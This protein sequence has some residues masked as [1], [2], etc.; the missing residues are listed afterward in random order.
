[1]SQYYKSS[2]LTI[3]AGKEKCNDGFFNIHNECENHPG[4]GV[5]KDLLSMSFLCPDGR[6]GTVYFKEE[7]PYFLSWEPIS[8]RAWTLQERVLSPRVLSYG[9]RLVWQCH[10]AQHSEGGVED[11]S[12]DTRASDHRKLQLSF[13]EVHETIRDG[14]EDTKSSSPVVQLSE[15]L[16]DIRYRA[17]HEFSCRKLTFPEDKLPAIAGLA[18]EFGRLSGDEYLA[19]LW[20]SQ[21]L[22]ELM[23]STYPKLQLVRSPTR[24]APLW[25][26]ASLDNDITFGCLPPKDAMVLAQVLDCSVTPRSSNSPCTEVSEATIETNAPVLDLG[27][28]NIKDLLKHEYTIPGPQ[29]RGYDW[30][31]LLIN[32]L[33]GGLERQKVGDE[34]DWE[35]PENVVLLATFV[36]SIPPSN[37]PQG[38]EESPQDEKP[39]DRD[40]SKEKGESQTSDAQAIDKADA[41]AEP[42]E[43]EERQGIDELRE[44]EMPQTIDDDTA[45][46]Y[47][48]ALAGKEDDTYERIGSFTSLKVKG[49]SNLG[50][51][52][53]NVRIV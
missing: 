25:S 37:Q 27:R 50:Y 26:W 38:S 31:K 18:T 3:R 41:S 52:K 19:G 21:L 7:S 42:T 17:V 15:D 43:V 47:G 48:L 5:G 44:N 20:R 35:P 10:N 24:R 29:G 16:S 45:I 11:W 36:C 34:K 4:S 53:K 6:I 39:Q 1:M 14:S 33:R 32:S 28:N 22:R 40:G 23:W 8:S 12:F 51:C 46:V 49:L 30:R 13:T 2:Y 9:L